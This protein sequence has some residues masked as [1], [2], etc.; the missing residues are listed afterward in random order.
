[1]GATFT[2]K[3]PRSGEH[4][5]GRYRLP[6]LGFVALLGPSA[7]G[8]RV[9]LL[10]GLYSLILIAY[11]LWS[12]RLTVTFRD[13]AGLGYL[14]CLFDVALTLPLAMWGNPT[15]LTGLLVGAWVLSVASSVVIRRREDLAERARRRGPRLVDPATGLRTSVCFRDV[16]REQA[17]VAETN[18]PTFGVMI[19]RVHR[20]EELVAYYG[21]DAAERALGAVGRRATREVGRSAEAFRLAADLLALAWPVRGSVE[22]SEFA[23][24]VSKAVNQRLIEGRKIDSFVGYAVYPR[25][26]RTVDELLASADASTS[27]RSTRRSVASAGVQPRVSLAR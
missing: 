21:R 8:L 6:L 4:S 25:D 20:F 15:W 3:R 10:S 18:G 16:V 24:A 1:M 7:F 11:A 2:A 26:G 23:A 14:L 13:D 22:A 27:L 19:V 17:E 12:L 5:K 9:G